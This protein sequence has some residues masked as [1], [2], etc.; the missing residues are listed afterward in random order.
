[1]SILAG[2]GHQEHL[3]LVYTPAYD[4]DA[5]RTPMALACLATGRDT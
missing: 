5:N 4:P 3:S 2:T 1:M